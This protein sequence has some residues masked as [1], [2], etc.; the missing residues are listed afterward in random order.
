MPLVT[1]TAAVQRPEPHFQGS[2]YLKTRE[3]N[4]DGASE[5]GVCKSPSAFFIPDPSMVAFKK[6]ATLRP[7]GES[8]RLKPLS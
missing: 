5:W 1:V 8:T 6:P 3:A 2:C 4:L 7:M